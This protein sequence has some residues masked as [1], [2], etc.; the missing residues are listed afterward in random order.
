MK[1]ELIFGDLS[2]RGRGLGSQGTCVF[3]GGGRG[4]LG[5]GYLKEYGAWQNLILSHLI[6]SYLILS[7]PFHLIPHPITDEVFVI[8]AADTC[9]ILRTNTE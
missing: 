8:L 7:Y 4:S 6:S 3:G 1:E 2:L 9:N 5:G